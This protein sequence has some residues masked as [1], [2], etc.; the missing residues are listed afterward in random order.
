[1]SKL[2]IRLPF[3]DY[4]HK[5]LLCEDPSLTK[6][7][8]ADECNFNNVLD[9]WQ[10]SGLITHINPSSPIYSDVSNYVDYQHSLELIRSAQDSFD[11]LPSAVRD[12]FA[13]DPGRLIAFL[14]DPSNEDEARRLGLLNPLAPA[15]VDTAD[16]QG[17]SGGSSTASTGGAANVQ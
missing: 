4:P 7:S 8:F 1:M 17:S 13:N 6:Q 15:V 10:Q 5:G 2:E 12:R 16:H 14:S 11:S 9:K 3:V